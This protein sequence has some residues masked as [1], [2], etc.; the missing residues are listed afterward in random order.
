MTAHADS[1]APEENS[2]LCPALVL[3]RFKAKRRGVPRRQVVTD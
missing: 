3:A 1:H 2:A